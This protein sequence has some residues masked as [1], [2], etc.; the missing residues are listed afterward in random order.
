ML[1]LL[2]KFQIQDHNLQSKQLA[3]KI[4][5]FPQREEL[6]FNNFNLLILPKS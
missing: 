4:V 1:G 2:T 6:T 5:L 3:L